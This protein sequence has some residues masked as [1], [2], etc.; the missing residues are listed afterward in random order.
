MQQ[1]ICLGDQ[2]HIAFNFYHLFLYFSILGKR[3]R[4]RKRKKLSFRL[5]IEKV[6]VIDF[7]SK[8]DGID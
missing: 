1:I 5:S 7:G 8:V 3:M 2:V 6:L 4:K